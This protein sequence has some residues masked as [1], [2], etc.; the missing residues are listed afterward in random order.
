M[1]QVESSLRVRC[2]M[3]F[4]F[5]VGQNET[6][7]LEVLRV[8]VNHDQPQNRGVGAARAHDLG[9]A[10]IKESST[11]RI[12]SSLVKGL[13]RIAVPSSRIPWVAI[14]PSAYPDM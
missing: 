9:A 10:A 6:H 4:Q 8:V 13:R 2:A 5:G 11:R 7:K 12:T 3:D 1:N 14:S